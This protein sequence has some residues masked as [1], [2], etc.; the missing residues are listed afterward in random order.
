MKNALLFL[1]LLLTVTLF[2]CEEETAPLAIPTAYDATDY[3]TNTV[4]E[5]E[6]RSN[7]TNYINEVK[8][9]RVA[10]TVVTE[11]SLRAVFTAGGNNS[12]SNI[13]PSN[14][15]DAH[16]AAFPLI[17]KASKSPAY[18]FGKGPADNPNGGA[19][20]GYLFDKTGLEFEQILDKGAFGAIFYKKGAELLTN[21]T[22][23]NL[24]QAL[25]LYGANPTF[26]NTPTATK[27]EQPD[28]WMANYGARRTKASGG[29]YTQV[30][31]AF[32]KAQAAIKAGSK[33]TT[34][35]DAATAEILLKWEQ[36]NA[37]T[38][39]NYLYDVETK[40]ASTNPTDAVKASAMHAYGEAVGFL[41]GFRQTSKK[42]I[43]DVQ[44]DD[45][46]TKMNATAPY[47]IVGS[48]TEIAKLVQVR[49]DLQAIYGFTDAQM[50]EFKNNY[51]TIEGR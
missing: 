8:K 6:L 19:N 7:F 10:G 26:P 40:L 41:G 43:T 3:K 46:L 28:S 13:A 4:A 35:R 33:Y 25:A 34:E 38:V 32:I 21:P 30:R 23:A 1:S 2:S 48:P 36:I 9:G 14:V 51:V 18:Q 44:I 39:I 31:D 16:L 22:A 47:K 42:K 17:E 20:G 29:L 37:A 11:A 5:Y 45:A 15:R 49:K 24:D 12:V 27:T 50:E